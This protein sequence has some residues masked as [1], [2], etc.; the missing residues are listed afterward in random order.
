MCS[1]SSITPLGIHFSGSTGVSFAGADDHQFGKAF[2][3][4][5]LIVAPVLNIA[6]Q[7]D[8]GRLSEAV[9][10]RMLAGEPVDLLDLLTPG[11]RKVLGNTGWLMADRLLRMGVGLF[12]SVWVARY[13]GPARFGSLNFALSYVALF[14]SLMTLGLDGIVVREI[15]RD[16]SEAPR[17]LGSALALRLGGSVVAI[18]VCVTS[19]RLLE[20]HDPQALILVLIVSTTL[21]FQ[22]FDTIDS[23][24]Q[25]QVRSKLT[26]WAKNAAFLVVAVAR[27]ILIHREAPV[28]AFAVAGVAEFA[29]GAI[30]LLIAYRATG[31]NILRWLPQRQMAVDL[32]KQGWPLMLS[33]MAIM[34][35][36]RIDTVML[37]LM[38]GDAAAGMYAAA[39]RISEVWYFIPTAIVTSVSPAIMRSK[40]DPPLYYRRLRHLFSV[41]ILTSLTIGSV[42]ALTSH[43][44]V[45]RLYSHSYNNAGP[46]LAVHIWASIFV[47]LGVAQG[48]WDISENLLNLALY[49]TTAGAIANILLNLYLIPHYSA[50]GA[51]AATVISYAISS[52]FA[53]VFSPR[54]RP[55]FFLQLKA[56]VPRFILGGD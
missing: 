7:R 41:M 24:F 33:G 2:K 35:Y 23:Y 31:G 10:N 29:L 53:N 32:L 4:K 45:V 11:L 39:T 43:W 49:R 52:F 42:I 50:L 19:A 54:T 15:V 37:K 22:A 30:G 44:I 36:M 34:I 13:L 3:F 12:V 9:S 27:V 14:A 48:P 26:V 38:Q 47:F 28:W 17:I 16:S 25:S 8:M 40:G 46:V 20:P 55:I 1:S 56:A 51:A 21:T 18:L 5:R 6:L